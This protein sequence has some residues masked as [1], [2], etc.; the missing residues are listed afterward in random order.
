MDFSF[1]ES[2]LCDKSAEICSGALAKER[3]S[4]SGNRLGENDIETTA[5]KSKKIETE[6]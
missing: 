6:M 3:V 5:G 1:V 2:K 4:R